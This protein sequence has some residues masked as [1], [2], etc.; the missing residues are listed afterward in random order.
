MHSVSM[1]FW[2]TQT[3]FL[4]V[5]CQ[6]T[7]VNTNEEDGTWRHG[8]WEAGCLLLHS[9]CTSSSSSSSTNFI[10]TQVLQKLQ[11]RWA[12]YSVL[13][14]DLYKQT[15]MTCMVLAHWL[16][17]LEMSVHSA[18]KTTAGDRMLM[19]RAASASIVV[20]MFL[21]LK[22]NVNS[23]LLLYSVCWHLHVLCGC[24]VSELPLLF[25]YCFWYSEPTDEDAGAEETNVLM[26]FDPRV[27][28]RLSSING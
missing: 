23:N 10:A 9:I 2:I 19:L 25:A 8:T 5:E 4:A 21:D 6:G 11:G 18:V 20:Y 27:F 16:L 22:R 26:P 28:Q 13:A 14:T 17:H 1:D 7:L 15:S 12:H 24:I 3:P